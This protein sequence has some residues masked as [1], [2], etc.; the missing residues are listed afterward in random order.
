[1]AAVIDLRTGRQV[2]Q[3]APSPRPQL[4]VLEGGRSPSARVARQT[5]LVRRAAV[6]V[7]AALVIVV[8]A[9]VLGGLVGS[10]AGA[11]DGVPAASG[12]VH[13]VAPGDTMWSLAGDLAPGLDRRVAVDDLLALNGEA[14]LR[15]GQDLRLPASFG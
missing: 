7:V 3:P 6:A 1:M 10:L 9:Q 5:Y 4:R 2:P 8:L 11:M 13:V 15:V 12:A 14:P